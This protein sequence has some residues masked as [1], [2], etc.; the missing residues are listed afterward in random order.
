MIENMKF[1]L[2]LK[3]GGDLVKKIYL[4]LVVSKN[5]VLVMFVYGG[6]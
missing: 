1:I 4:Y 6:F 3:K 2:L 5:W